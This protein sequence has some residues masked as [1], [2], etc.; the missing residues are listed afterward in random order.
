MPTPKEVLN[1]IRWRHDALEHVVI[2]YLHRGAPGDQRTVE[3]SKVLELGRSFFRVEG[4]QGGTSLP[5]HR[6]L[7]IEWEGRRV[8]QRHASRKG[9][10]E[11]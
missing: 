1:E 7:W 10:Q 4:P 3:G 9:G 8:W 2:G 5:Y 6:V 11:E